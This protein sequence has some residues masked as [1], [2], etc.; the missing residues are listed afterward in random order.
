MAGRE[1]MTINTKRLSAFERSLARFHVGQHVTLSP[2][3]LAA[4]LQGTARTPAG[5]VTSFRGGWLNVGRD[6]IKTSESYDP[7]LWEPVPSSK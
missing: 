1:E 2:V 3:G 6:G 4:G 5:R 7:R